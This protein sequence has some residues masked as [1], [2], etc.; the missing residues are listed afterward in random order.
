MAVEGV[1]A[2]IAL[3]FG[4][5]ADQKIDDSFSEIADVFIDKVVADD[6]NLSGGGPQLDIGSRRVGIRVAHEDAV[7]I[8][9]PSE[10]P[11][12][13]PAH[14]AMSLV[15]VDIVDFAREMGTPLA[16]AEESPNAVIDVVVFRQ[17]PDDSDVPRVLKKHL[18]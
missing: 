17:D 15:P 9:V 6:V 18:H 4:L 8:S 16:V 3:A 11:V 13:N 2:L 1:D 7:E 14:G 10:D 12:E 5:L